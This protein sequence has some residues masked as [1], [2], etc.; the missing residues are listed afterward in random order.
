MGIVRH[1]FA[2][3]YRMLSNPAKTLKEIGSEKPL[4]AL[5]YL[6]MIGAV[7]AFLTPL[8]IYLGFED[9]NGLHAGGQA[10]VLAMDV[11][12]L[13]NL[14]IACRPFL[15]EAFYVVVLAISTGYLHVIFKVAGGK[16]SIKD[17]FKMIA[18][19]DAPGLLFGWIPYIAT[20]SAVWAAVIQILIGSIVIH[21]ISWTRATIIFAAILG[22]GIIDIALSPRAS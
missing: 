3:A 21:E 10:E 22:I 11:S 20:F 1:N 17:T 6:L 15:I 7:T 14:G 5:I 13:Y 16:G 4:H 8:Q 19:G 2:I 12:T 18:Y 9:I